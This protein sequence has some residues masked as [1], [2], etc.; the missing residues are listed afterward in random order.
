MD[1]DKEV[2]FF[3]LRVYVLRIGCYGLFFFLGIEFC[4]KIKQI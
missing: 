4:L 2:F 1:I 3:F